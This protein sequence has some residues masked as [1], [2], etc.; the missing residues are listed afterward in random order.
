MYLNQ[1]NSVFGSKKDL[2]LFLTDSLLM[3]KIKIR[4]VYSNW[5]GENAELTQSKKGKPNLRIGIP[6]TDSLLKND[7]VFFILEYLSY[8]PINQQVEQRYLYPQ[9]YM[10]KVYI[11]QSVDEELHK[12]AKLF[13]D[14]KLVVKDLVLLDDDNVLNKLI[15]KINILE[16]E[17]NRVKT[18]LNNIYK[19]DEFINEVSSR[20]YP[21][22][23]D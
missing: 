20:I 23:R 10:D 2:S 19:Q 16:N 12:D 13:I 11:G 5:T 8:N 22:R 7:R 21:S 15:S 6:N 1:N 9:R 4:N 14:G 3:S 18:K 17:L